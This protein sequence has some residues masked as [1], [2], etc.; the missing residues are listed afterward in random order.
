MEKKDRNTSKTV[1]GQG[2]DDAR[3]P[4]VRA[5]EHLYSRVKVSVR[6]VDTLIVVCVLLVVALIFIGVKLR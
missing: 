1:S 4:V 5:K 3:N 6:Q 2:T